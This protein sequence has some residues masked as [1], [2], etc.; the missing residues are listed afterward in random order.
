MNKYQKILETSAKIDEEWLRKDLSQQVI[1]RYPVPS[2]HPRSRYLDFYILVTQNFSDFQFRD[3]DLLLIDE[4]VKSRLNTKNQGILTETLS[5]VEGETKTT[6]RLKKFL[7]QRQLLKIERII[8][9]GG[10]LL[11]NVAGYVAEQLQKDL[12]LIPTT[13]IAMSDGSIGGKVRLNEVEDDKFVKHAYKSFYEPSQ[14]IA[15]YHF[16]G[17]L[18]ENQI[19]Y[20]LAEIIKHALYQSEKLASYLLSDK[21]NPFFERDTLFRAILW[22]ADLKRICLEQDP[23]ENKDGSYFILRAAHD[24]SD[25]LEEKSKFTLSHGEAV[26]QAMLQDLRNNSKKLQLLRQIYSKMKITL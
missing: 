18:N 9:V 19:R 3:D 23:E 12:I 14:I 6:A 25:K 16:L 21:F 20:G 11:M 4:T 10:G 22:V 8:G 24:I 13:V 15:D 5:A 1:I 2:V 7:K 26:L 17:S